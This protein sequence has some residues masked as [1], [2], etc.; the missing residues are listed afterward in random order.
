[1]CLDISHIIFFFP[2]IKR[3]SGVKLTFRWKIRWSGTGGSSEFNG[4]KTL[5]NFWS[6]SHSLSGNTLLFGLNN[7]W[8]MSNSTFRK[9]YKRYTYVWK[10]KLNC[11]ITVWTN[12]TCYLRADTLRI[13][14]LLPNPIQG[15]YILHIYILNSVVNIFV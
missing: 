3:R 4:K 6:A 5:W 12:K 13:I 14:L 11:E 2:I 7:A 9:Y 10:K 8:F 1:M 15:Q